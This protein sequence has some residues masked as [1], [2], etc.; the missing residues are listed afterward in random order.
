MVRCSRR[1][2]LG[3]HDNFF[4][5]GG[6]SLQATQIVARLRNVFHGKIQLATFFEYPTIAELAVVMDSRTATL[7]HDPSAGSLARRDRSHV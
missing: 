6:H 1:K 4:E 7:P 3:I 2:Q 5:V